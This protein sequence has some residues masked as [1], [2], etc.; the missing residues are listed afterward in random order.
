MA[1][2]GY[3]NNVKVFCMDKI[4][5]EL[6][7]LFTQSLCRK[8]TDIPVSLFLFTNIFENVTNEEDNKEKD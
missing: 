6:F 2:K 4:N 7:F 8:K 1:P 3:V 5:H